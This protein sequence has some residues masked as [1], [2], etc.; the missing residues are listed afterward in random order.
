M[1]LS[2][3]E[4][5]SSQ[6]QQSSSSRLEKVHQVKV[7]ESGWSVHK[8]SDEWSQHRN[9]MTHR[10]KR[11]SSSAMSECPNLIKEPFKTV[12][13]NANMKWTRE[14]CCQSKAIHRRPAWLLPSSWCQTLW[15]IVAVSQS[16]NW[17]TGEERVPQLPRGHTER[18]HA[19]ARLTC[20]LY[21][22][23]SQ[24][25]RER[26]RN[27]RKIGGGSQETKKGNKLYIL[28]ALSTV[29][30]PVCLEYLRMVVL[31]QKV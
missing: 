26:H 17:C 12:H 5:S 14:G 19:F 4:S 30:L 13:L 18:R 21:L 2:E 1:H 25:T 8:K 15:A 11:G 31:W 29:A 27:S 22:H 24:L 23:I 3:C 28:W 16:I 10:P 20:A 6:L 7:H 9:A